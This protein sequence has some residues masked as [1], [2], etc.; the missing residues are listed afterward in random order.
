MLLTGTIIGLG[1][2]IISL[3]PYCVGQSSHKIQWERMQTL[4]LNGK[5]IKNFQLSSVYH[6]LPSGCIL[7]T[8]LPLAK[9]MNPLP[10]SYKMSFCYSGNKKSRSS[11]SKSDLDV[12]KAPQVWLL[13]YSFLS[14]DPVTLKTCALET[15]CPSFPLS[16]LPT[17]FSIHTL[18]GQR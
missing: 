13:G 1:S 2:H 3:L 7:F 14:A 5:S 10:K 16:V 18:V 6:S 12:A 11:S 4:S 8:S 15:G 9:Y 17:P